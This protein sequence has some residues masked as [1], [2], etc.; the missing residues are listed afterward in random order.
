MKF[1]EVIVRK[2][3]ENVLPEVAEVFNSLYNEK[4]GLEEA[5]IT[6]AVLLDKKLRGEVESIVRNLTGKEPMLKEEVDPEIIGGYELA[7]GDRKIEA[8]VSGQLR[9]LKLKFSKENN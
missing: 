2:N 9:A 5:V 8:S 1:F 3:R 4:K 7:I 6:T